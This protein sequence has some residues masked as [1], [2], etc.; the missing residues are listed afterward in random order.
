MAD[1]AVIDLALAGL[2]FTFGSFERGGESR[3]AEG[4][5]VGL[6]CLAMAFLS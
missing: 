3:G 5:A 6:F 2:A 1:G 4:F